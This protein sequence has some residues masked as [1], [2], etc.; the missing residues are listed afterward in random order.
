MFVLVVWGLVTVS[1]N[2]LERPPS[3]RKQEDKQ[4]HAKD[5]EIKT[6]K[7]ED[8]TKAE[9]SPLEGVGHSGGGVSPQG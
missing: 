1:E 7:P 5:N 2:Q 3:D 4:K 8:V 9:F 6:Q